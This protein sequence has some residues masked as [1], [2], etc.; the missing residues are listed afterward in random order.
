MK[1]VALGLMLLAHSCGAHEGGW[2]EQLIPHL[3]CGM[4]VAEV[5]ALAGR[6]VETTSN[7]PDLGTHRVDGKWSDVWLTFREDRLVSYVTGRIDGVASVRLSPKQNLCS[8]T[9]TFFLSVEWV[10]PLE[11]ADVFLDGKA[12]EDNASS[13]VILEISAGDPELKIFKEGYQPI[14]KNLSLGF[15]D[16]GQR[17]ILITAADLRQIDS[18]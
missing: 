5:Q 7:K 11:G 17:K 9:L 2:V 13:G 15:E 16:P 6:Q 3:Q 4:S 12:V 18:P 8:G 1:A 10:V 14:I